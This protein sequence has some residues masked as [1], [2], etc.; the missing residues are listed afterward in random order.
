M[1]SRLLH[2]EGNELK[3][4]LPFFALYFLVFCLLSMADGLSLA[5]F[6]KRVG[7]ASLPR[8][9]ALTAAL[10]LAMIA[11]YVARAERFGSTKTFQLILA[12]TGATFLGAWLSIEGFAGEAGRAYGLLFAAREVAYTLLVMHFGTFLQDYFTRVE[13]NRVLMIVYAGGRFGGIAGG[14]ALELIATHLGL[15]NALLACIGLSV[16]TM[17]G[18]TFTRRALSHVESPEDERSDA[19]L[20]Q[21]ED[22]ES[23]E[24]GAL[25]SIRGFLTFALRSP[26][27]RW[28]SISSLVFM[29]A[30]W[31]LN[32]QYNSYFELHFASDVELAAFMGRYTMIA[33][34]VSLV[35]QLFVMSRL[36][37]AI[38]LKASN[39][40]YAV[41][42]SVS[43]G[44]NAIHMGFG[45][46][47]ASRA[48]E[49]ELRFGMRNPVNQLIVNKLSKPLR[50]RVRAWS[51]G[52]LIPVATLMTSGALAIFAAGT[53]ALVG[54]FGV[55]LGA[56]YL[57]SCV[58]VNGSFREGAAT[59]PPARAGEEPCR[60]E[61]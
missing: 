13:L 22:A 45:Q 34:T 59:P 60:S 40:V 61:S 31:V 57:G 15:S 28:T 38:G 32:Y 55:V 18:V 24:R 9:Y 3:R 51:L 19:G 6:V 36:V 25:R 53:G 35:L 1:L 8:Y 50:V 14:L 44:A 4:L 56:G 33:L 16:I 11:V 54:V 37:A 10:N 29:G 2:L 20:V 26:L 30:R 17:V 12:M 42:V 21:G 27:V 47:I 46:A 23:L 58:G 41:L 43:L 52:V 5:L 7:A 48:L 39:L 49:T